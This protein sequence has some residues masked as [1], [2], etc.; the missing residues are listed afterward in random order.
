MQLMSIM[1]TTA[2]FQI[3]RSVWFMLMARI[4]IRESKFVRQSDR[5]SKKSDSRCLHTLLGVLTEIESWHLP[6]SQTL[7]HRF[8]ASFQFEWLGG[9]AVRKNKVVSF[10]NEF[11]CQMD[12]VLPFFW[13]FFSS[14][15][16]IWV[17]CNVYNAVKVYK[18]ELWFRIIAM[19]P[20][21]L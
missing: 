3:L 15:K 13:V 7:L 14:L 21:S 19:V 20:C 2:L 1:I 8:Q 12:Q 5:S 6:S 18:N 11:K 10:L 16:N 17:I 9:V 4:G